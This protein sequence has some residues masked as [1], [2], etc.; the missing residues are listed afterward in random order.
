MSKIRWHLGRGYE[1]PNKLQVP[2]VL[3]NY[4]NSHRRDAVICK[5][6]EDPTNNYVSAALIHSL[7]MSKNEAVNLGG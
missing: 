1:R 2:D 5:A 3:R 6:P 4:L 7:T